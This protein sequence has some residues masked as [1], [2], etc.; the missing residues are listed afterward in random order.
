MKVMENTGTKIGLTTSVILEYFKYHHKHVPNPP[1]KELQRWVL[2]FM[3]KED[4]NSILTKLGINYLLVVLDILESN[5]RYRMCSKIIK[6]INNY[7]KFYN[8]GY[9]TTLKTQ[10]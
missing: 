10:K 7:N 1:N 5:N 2:H 3:L 9:S 8:T 6:L 4:F